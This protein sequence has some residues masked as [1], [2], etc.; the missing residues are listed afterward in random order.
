VIA[1]LLISAFAAFQFKM[2]II[3]SSFKNQREK[4][5]LTFCHYSFSPCCGKK[6]REVIFYNKKGEWLDKRLNI[7]NLFAHIRF[8]KLLK[9]VVLLKS[10]AN[11]VYVKG[12]LQMYSSSESTGHNSLDEKEVSMV[13]EMLSNDL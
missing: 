5:K 1:P 3:Y 11:P 13:T 7:M 4:M 8:L 6:S 12:L 2:D 10:K 9:K